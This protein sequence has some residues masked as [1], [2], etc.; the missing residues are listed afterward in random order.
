MT[1]DLSYQIAQ[2]LGDSHQ[3]IPTNYLHAELL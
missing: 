2:S 3:I 1:D